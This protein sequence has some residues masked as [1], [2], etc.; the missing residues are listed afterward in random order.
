[1]M[2]VT[3]LVRVAAVAASLTAGALSVAPAYAAASDIDLLKEYVGDWRGRGVLTGAS[4]ETVVCRMSVKT[5]NQDKINYSGRCTMAGTTISMNGTVAYVNNRYEAAM[6]SASFKGVAVGR[7]R[8]N[9]IVFDMQQREKDK[10]G[11]DMDVAA[12]M[13]LAGGKINVNFSVVFPKTG[14]RIKATVPFTK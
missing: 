13:T 2:N 9:S 3:S 1:M 10:E 8:G 5:G 4:S 7:K 14:D 6:T 12:Q 11:N